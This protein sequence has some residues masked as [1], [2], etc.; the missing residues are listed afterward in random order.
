MEIKL[1]A[2]AAKL[3]AMGA[4]LL[5]AGAANAGA[6]ITNGTVTLGVNDEGHLNVPGGTPSLS[7]TTDVGL[8]YNAT[9]A[10]ATAPGCLCEGWGAGLLSSS[11][12]GYA[13]VSTDGGANNLA[14]VSF[15][16]TADSAT[17][18]VRIGS[19]LEVTHYY[20]PSTVA[21]LYQVDVSLKNISGSNFAAGD[22]VYRRVMD[23]DIEPTAFRENVTI[24]GVPAALGLA[25]GNNIRRT[26]DNG[27]DTANP[28]TTSGATI[29]CPAN[30]NFTDCGP[31]DH[32]AVFD[33]E[34][35][36][37]AAGATRNFVTY[38]G[39]AGNEA[40]ALAALASVGA[41]LYSLGQTSTDPT[42]GTPSTF[43]FGFGSSGGILT[44]PSSVPE[45]GSLTLAGLG[46]GMLALRR[47]QKKPA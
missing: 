20:H 36:A 29:S 9:G 3:S 42:H 8:R 33:F 27:F 41:G 45:P 25:N 1:K 15:T 18:V 40:D 32:G 21:N 39:A 34:F 23:W 5:L 4:G 6:I 26:G 2:L 11:V 16:S 17:S 38:Y 31:A 47:R 30:A 22:L 14:L 37:L 7:G 13:N 24:N 43:M 44:P 46:M 19:S 12:S 10:E 28:L 35:E